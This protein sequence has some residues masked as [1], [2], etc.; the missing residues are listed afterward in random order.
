MIHNERIDKIKN[1]LND[2]ETASITFLCKELF[3]SR[4]TLRRDL[5]YLEEKGVVRRIHGGVSL[6]SNSALEHS[7]GIR[8]GENRDKKQYIA[9]LANSYLRND[10]VIF[11]DSSSTVRFLCPYI[12]QYNNITVITNGIG[13]AMDLSSSNVNVIIAGGYLKARSTSIIGEKCS[14]FLKDFYADIIFFSCNSIDREG[15]YEPDDRQALAKKHMIKNST[16]SIL[17]ADNTKINRKSYYKIGDINIMDTIISNKKVD[18][19]FANILKYLGC[20]VIY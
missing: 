10:L 2:K 3:C 12:K 6:V 16:R 17:L 13:I 5:I 19:T 1:I 15:I 18:D 9:S 11:L 7:E 14:N 20:E 8:M 4:S